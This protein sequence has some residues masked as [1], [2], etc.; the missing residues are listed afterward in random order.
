M[1]LN[2]SLRQQANFCQSLVL[3]V[4][5]NGDDLL[6][7]N[8][9]RKTT[10]MIGA[11][12]PR[13][14]A[15]PKT[16]LLLFLCPALRWCQ[17][18]PSQSKSHDKAEEPAAKIEKLLVEPKQRRQLVGKGGID[19]WGTMPFMWWQHSHLRICFVKMENLHWSTNLTNSVHLALEDGMCLLVCNK[20]PGGFLGVGCV[21]A[22][23][24]AGGV[25]A[26]APG[27]NHNDIAN[28][29]HQNEWNVFQGIEDIVDGKDARLLVTTKLPFM[30]IEVFVNPLISG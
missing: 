4:L 7:P 24:L 29:V 3:Q 25:E 15:L 5:T 30:C 8:N 2:V 28:I 17:C 20:I 14:T 11:A 26:F 23:H 13:K 6:I 1:C 9:V 16:C 22:H 27:V 10:E 21:V 12:K 18:S 19:F